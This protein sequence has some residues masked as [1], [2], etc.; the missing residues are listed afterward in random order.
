MYIYISTYIYAYIY[1]Y[2]CVLY[3]HINMYIYI[4]IYTHIYI[5]IYTYMYIYIY[6]YIYPVTIMMLVQTCGSLIADRCCLLAA[7]E[8]NFGAKNCCDFWFE[9]FFSATGL[10]HRHS[11]ERDTFSSRELLCNL[12]LYDLS[13]WKFIF[14]KGNL[15][16]DIKLLVWLK[17]TEEI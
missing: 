10:Y 9:F 3:I 8:Q 15:W 1:I 14:W 6:A 11:R 17:Q 16:S 12:L 4:N 7:P 2:I 5:F 13:S